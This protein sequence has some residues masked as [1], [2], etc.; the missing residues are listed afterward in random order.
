M[1]YDSA[2]D[3][4]VEALRA[5]ARVEVTAGLEPTLGAEF[6]AVRETRGH[7]LAMDL[8]ERSAL[9]AMFIAAERAQGQPSGKFQD[10]EIVTVSFEYV[11]PATPIAKIDSRWPLLRAVWAELRK[12][13]RAGTV[14]DVDVLAAAGALTVQEGSS[15]VEFSFG[16]EA[17]NAYPYFLGRIQLRWRPPSASTYEPLVELL[18]DINRVDG[19]PDLQPQ[20]QVVSTVT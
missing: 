20:V 2:T 10:D 12:A 17:S 15:T 14:G 4:L 8:I 11:A 3:P 6:P 19:D 16:Q 5:I 9:P 13:V 18:A 1:S 7:P